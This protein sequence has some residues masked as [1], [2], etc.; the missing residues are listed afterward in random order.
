MN[1]GGGND[2]LVQKCMDAYGVKTVSALAERTGI[3]YTTLNP[4][5]IKGPSRIG[6]LLLTSLIE[7]HELR[8]S[9]EEV[10]KAEEMR[11]EAIDRIKLILGQ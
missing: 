8:K 11:S 5:N 7:N 9:V 3:P 1:N 10:I 6:T 2:I 4:W